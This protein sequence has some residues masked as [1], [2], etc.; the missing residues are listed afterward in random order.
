[1][2]FT[3]IQK[4]GQ[5]LPVFVFQMSRQEKDWLCAILDLYPQLDAG[6]HRITRGAAPELIAEQQLL[7]EAMTQQRQDHKRQLEKFLGTPG[8]FHLET[9]DQ[10]GFALNAGQMD[11]MLQV[12][13]DVRVGCWVKLGRPD[14]ETV[15]QGE[16]AD[17]QA[18]DMAAL[19]LSGYFQMSL[20]EA[21]RRPEP[22]P[23]N[24]S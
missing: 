10:Y 13:N 16:L 1:M 21:C 2:K 4:G 9:A 23:E 7:E 8:R 3:R 20:L 24:I 15:R 11:W 12:L 18:R 6:S 14:L 19:E 22:G 5:G 17:D